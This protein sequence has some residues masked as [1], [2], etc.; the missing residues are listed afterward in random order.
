M[1]A[2]DKPVLIFKDG[3]YYIKQGKK[4]TN[5]GRSKR[6]AEKLLQEK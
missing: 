6:Y 4:E 3:Y 2:K 1:A 5:V